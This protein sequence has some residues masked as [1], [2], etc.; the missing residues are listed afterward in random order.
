MKIS[1]ILRNKPAHTGT[2]VVTISP[3]GTVKDLVAL[4]T[5]HKIG[6]LVVMDGTHVAG[7]VSER[8]IVRRLNDAGADVLAGSVADIMTA[9]VVSCG[10]E[11]DIDDIATT[12]TERRIRHMPVLDEQALVGLV[13]IGD[14]VSSRMNQLEQ[15]RGQLE[16]YITG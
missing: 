3:S 6:A 11:D 2:E 10:P 1:D 7:I 4:L 9:T 16:Q 12:M 14:V 13:S 15:D 8:D 5:Q